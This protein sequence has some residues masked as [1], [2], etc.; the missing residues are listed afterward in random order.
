MIID[1]LYVVGISISPFEADAPL[2]VD[3]DAVLS[4]AIPFQWLQAIAGEGTERL[5][6]RC[7]IEHIQLA[8]SLTFNGL[9]T[10]N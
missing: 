2:I 1:N 9:K 7:G 8:E 5:K 3:S 4:F 10:A 6:I